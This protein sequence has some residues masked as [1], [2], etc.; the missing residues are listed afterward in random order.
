MLGSGPEI[1]SVW[2]YVIANA[3]DGS[4]EL[5]PRLISICIGISAEKAEEAIT[6]LCGPDPNSRSSEEEGRRLVREGEF[7]Y[8]VVNHSVYRN[9][10]NEEE[11]RTYNRDK[12]REHRA[13]IKMSKMSNLS[14]TNVDSQTMSAL[15]A[16]T[17]AE[18]DTEAEALEEEA[19]ASSLPETKPPVDE[20]P[21][22][23]RRK[24]TDPT[25]SELIA[26]RHAEFK[27]ALFAYWKFKNPDIEMPWDGQEGKALAMW[28]AS[29]PKTTLEQFKI[30]LRNRAKSE[31][32]HT[33]RPCKWLRSITDFASGPLD[34]FHK[35]LQRAEQR[36]NE[37]TFANTK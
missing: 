20:K 18:A 19:K 24:R 22:K 10:R 25:K 8:R 2:A 7:Q 29:A 12:Q 36:L 27:A 35:P 11:R 32:T 33:E 31:V 37:M 21:K 9:M 4:V 6:F 3:V 26:T 28:L 17:E 15:S 1:F 16:H 23:R 5:N 14:M 30:F 34:R 13:K